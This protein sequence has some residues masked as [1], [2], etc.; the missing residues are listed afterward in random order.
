MRG[1]GD[2]EGEYSGLELCFRLWWRDRVC[3]TPGSICWDV[4]YSSPPRRPVPRG[5]EIERDLLVD[6]VDTELDEEIDCDRG[7]LWGSGRDRGGL[8]DGSP[9][10]SFRCFSSFASS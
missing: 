10:I 1:G 3:E 5:G 9:G 6:M 7:L 4:T 2:L 8:G